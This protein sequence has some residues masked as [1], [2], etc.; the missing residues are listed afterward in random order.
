MEK[1]FLSKIYLCTVVFLSVAKLNAQV[2]EL[3][4]K[5]NESGDHYFKFTFLNQ[6]WIRFNQSNPVTTVLGEDA[7]Q[8]F[9]LG[10]RRTRMQMFGQITD[11]LFV[12]TQ[13]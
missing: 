4:I 9:D 8:T 10:L 13:L 5:F 3:K 6:T 1:R 11:R 2:P 12:Y 7:N